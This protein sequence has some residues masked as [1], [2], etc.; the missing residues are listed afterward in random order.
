MSCELN[1]LSV[2][3]CAVLESHAVK[4][5]VTIDMFKHKPGGIILLDIC[6]GRRETFGHS[7]VSQFVEKKI[8]CMGNIVGIGFVSCH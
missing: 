4:F 7:K 6:F 5:I 1:F 2:H 3:F 8:V